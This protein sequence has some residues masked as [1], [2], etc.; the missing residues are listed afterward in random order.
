MR[1]PNIVGKSRVQPVNGEWHD[2]KQQIAD[3]CEGRCIYCAISEARFGGIR[4]FH[5]EHY[6]PKKSFPKLIN[7]IRNLYL[8]CAICNVLKCDDWPCDPV[9]D[10]SAAAYPDPSTAD[11]NAIFQMSD[12]T[13]ELDSP[14]VAGKYILQRLLLNR[15]QLTLERRLAVVVGR[16]A[17]F[18][19]WVDTVSAEMTAGEAQETVR[20]LSGIITVHR[21]A[22]TEVRPYQDTDTKR[23]SVRP[24]ARKQRSKS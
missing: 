19:N 20:I 9:T 13:F 18:Q 22:L 6:R 3:H 10:H 11:Y 7:D 5:I 21:K 23:S 2:W 16:L 12:I 17:N 4:N 1:W 24:K 14:T 8:A 15:G